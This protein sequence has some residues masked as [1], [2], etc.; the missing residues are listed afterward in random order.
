VSKA[1]TG[2]VWFCIVG[3]LCLPSLAVLPWATLLLS[4]KMATGIAVFL[5]VLGALTTWR[6]F[7]TTNGL[8]ELLP[9]EVHSARRY[10]QLL[11]FP[12]IR[13][14]GW[15]GPRV[16]QTRWDEIPASS[17]N[18]AAFL[19]VAGVNSVQLV[20]IAALS[21]V[22][23]LDLGVFHMVKSLSS[24][25]LQWPFIESPLMRALEIS[26]L[27]FIALTVLNLLLCRHSAVNLVQKGGKP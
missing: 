26:F 17:K 4:L 21:L 27:S 7:V 14:L 16:S 10:A 23:S 19:V 11:I 12:E 2:I 5:T 8:N 20:A 1:L 3:I 25:A 24:L 13:F 6:R 9:A 22:V 18:V 15:K